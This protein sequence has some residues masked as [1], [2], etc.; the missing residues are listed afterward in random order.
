[1]MKS[2]PG[3]KSILLNR[4]NGSLSL[5]FQAL[6]G[7]QPKAV[8]I[9]FLLRP[10]IPRSRFVIAF[11]LDNETA[12]TLQIVILTNPFCLC[13]PPVFLHQVKNLA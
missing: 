3:W 5:M 7:E 10:R 6:L 1:M 9:E 4:S 2:A 8:K 13:F 11:Y 12:S